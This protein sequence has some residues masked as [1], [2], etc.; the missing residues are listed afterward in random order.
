MCVA[1]VVG[2]VVGVV[3]I[4]RPGTTPGQ[5]L[6]VTLGLGVLA[7]AV[8]VVIWGDQPRSFA[9]VPGAVTVLGAR[10]PAHYLLIIGGDAVGVRPAVAVLHPHRPG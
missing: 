9:G 4:G 8:E 2:L 5:A 1:A 7:Y 6:I 3:A 10:V